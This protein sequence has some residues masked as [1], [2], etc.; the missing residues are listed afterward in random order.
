[1]KIQEPKSEIKR[2]KKFMV[3]YLGVIG[4]QE[5]I[6]YLLK[7]AKY[8]KELPERNDVFWGIVGG[9]S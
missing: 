3:G 1:M 5:G 7:A 2:G 8:V 9:V 6:E 4:Q